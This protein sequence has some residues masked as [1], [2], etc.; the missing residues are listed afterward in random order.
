MNEITP[1]LSDKK[2]IET[3]VQDSTSNIVATIT[4]ILTTGKK[5]YILGLGRI[6]QAG[7]KGRFLDQFS[8]E[9]KELQEKG[10]V[11]EE[12]TQNHYARMSF[13]EL[14]NFI[15]SEVPDEARVHAIKS[16]FFKCIR[17]ETSESEAI[18]LY[19]YMQIV[20]ELSSSDL[21]IIKANYDITRQENITELNN[22]YVI[23]SW[24]HEV[25]QSAGHGIKDLIECREQHLMDLKIISQRIHQD[26][27]GFERTPYFRL[28]ELGYNIYKIIE[29][30]PTELSNS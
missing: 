5:E 22:R 20:K 12:W 16:L 17:T 2:S 29:E 28:T 25:A 30:T 18:I 21:L 14:M 26:K 7:I 23:S 19:Q 13:I 6:L 15:D 27:S 1:T 10:K 3:F 9:L 11:N 8:K 24:L 4:S